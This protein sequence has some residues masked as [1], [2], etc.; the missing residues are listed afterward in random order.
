M[1]KST[2][3]FSKSNS[4]SRQVFNQLCKKKTKAKRAEQAPRAPIF[5]LP[6]G[7]ENNPKSGN[8]HTGLTRN[9]A[10]TNIDSAAAQASLIRRP[11]WTGPE[12]VEFFEG[13]VNRLDEIKKNFD[14]HRQVVIN[15]LSGMGK[16]QLA[17][18][19]VQDYGSEYDGGFYFVN[20]ANEV[21]LLNGFKSFAQAFNLST[22]YQ[23]FWF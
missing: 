20:G 4:S 1:P 6:E 19:Y 2:K 12:V 15:G 21:A 17:L 9:G 10:K 14:S 23:A 5:P 11:V 7:D 13:R 16:T 18:K 3:D 8:V 22:K